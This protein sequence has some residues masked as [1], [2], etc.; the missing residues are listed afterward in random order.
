MF[1][2]CQPTWRKRN[3]ANG[4]DWNIFPNVFSSLTTAH[5]FIPFVLLAAISISSFFVINLSVAGELPCIN[6][7]TKWRGGWH[8]KWRNKMQIAWDKLIKMGWKIDNTLNKEGMTAK[9]YWYK[10]KTIESW[11]NSEFT[12]R[13]ITVEV[14]DIVGSR[15]LQLPPISGLSASHKPWTNGHCISCSFNPACLLQEYHVSF[16]V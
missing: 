12:S 11:V 6:K 8:R 3:E 13:T 2:V 16:K 1:T 5:S 14:G 9:P 4:D 7:T 15:V 10:H